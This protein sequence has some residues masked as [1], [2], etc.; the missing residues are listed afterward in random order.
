MKT[1]D[2]INKLYELEKEHENDTYN[3][4]ETRWVDVCKEVKAKLIELEETEYINERL[5]HTTVS[6]V[7]KLRDFFKLG[8]IGSPVS[9]MTALDITVSEVIS[10]TKRHRNIFHK[11]GD[12]MDR[13]WK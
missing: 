7:D 13:L 10:H 8:S 1:K 12:L 3:A 9:N 6:A 2:M 11:L 4:F 5:H